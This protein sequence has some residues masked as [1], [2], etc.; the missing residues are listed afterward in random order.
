MLQNS[1]IDP[2]FVSHRAASERE[3]AS[4]AH[5][6]CDFLSSMQWAATAAFPSAVLS[7]ASMAGWA[8]S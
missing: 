6:T 7:A 4:L 3:V 8:A 1:K 2:F 5:S